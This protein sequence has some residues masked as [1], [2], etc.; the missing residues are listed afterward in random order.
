MVAFI[1]F[2]LAD[3]LSIIIFHDYPIGRFFYL[4]V[5]L[6]SLEM[7]IVGTVHLTKFG[8]TLMASCAVSLSVGWI[9]FNLWLVFS[10]F[11]H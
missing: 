2:M 10:F 1:L 11:T 5:G 4:M 6:V 9:V 3:W 7:I 8:D